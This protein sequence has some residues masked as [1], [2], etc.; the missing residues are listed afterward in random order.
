MATAAPRPC[1]HPGC[2]VLVR[3]GTSRCQK[4]PA[5]VWA[6]KPTAAKR[7]TGRRLQQLRKE[8]FEREPLCRPCYKECRV[9]V[10]TMRDHIT[11]L[12][13]GG[14]D[15]ESNVQ[16]ICAECHDAKSKAERARGVRRAWN[17]Y[18]GT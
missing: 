2:G 16:P 3:D 15:V 4:H 17:N 14:Q 1:S 10:A 12:E 18:R 11:P 5:K 13:E 8:L 7:I 6:K 9:V